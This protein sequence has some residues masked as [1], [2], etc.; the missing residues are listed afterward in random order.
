MKNVNFFEKE[1]QETKK[2]VEK[3][4]KWLSYSFV[5]DSISRC[6]EVTFFLMDM[7]VDSREII[8]IYDS[9]REKLKNLIDL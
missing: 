4:P 2:L 5:Q 3:N 9:Y 1:Y 8:P 6:Q 7:G